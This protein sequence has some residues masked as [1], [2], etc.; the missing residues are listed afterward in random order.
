M[1]LPSPSLFT[2][3]KGHG[4][5]GV[6]DVPHF[7]FH[8]FLISNL[9]RNGCV[10]TPL[11]TEMCPTASVTATQCPPGP[12]FLGVDCDGANF[13]VTPL[14]ADMMP[15]G[16]VEVCAVEPGTYKISLVSRDD[17]YPFCRTKLVYLWPFSF[18]Y[19]III[20]Q[21]WEIT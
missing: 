14:P 19:E 2:T 17:L 5:P 7:D 16:Y 11:D 9:E 12:P 1:F 10:Q 3:L 15:D 18:P 13:A 4:P 20:I 8:F 21:E 6:Y